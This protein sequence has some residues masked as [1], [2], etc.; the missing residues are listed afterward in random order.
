MHSQLTVELGDCL[1]E[2]PPV[3]RRRR[4]RKVAARSRQRQLNRPS[5]RRVVAFRWAQRVPGRAFA[6][7]VR[8]LVLDILTLETSCH[9]VTML[10][11]TPLQLAL[12]PLEQQI[13]SAASHAERAAAALARRDASLC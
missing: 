5:P 11:V 8:L 3:G 4:S 6:Q 1:L 12:G 7:C 9:M 10:S 13:R 2:H